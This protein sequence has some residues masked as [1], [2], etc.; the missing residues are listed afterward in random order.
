MISFDFPLAFT[1]I[2]IFLGIWIWYT[3]EK[4]GNTS[5]NIFLKKYT[6]TPKISIFLWTIR[7][8][9]VIILASIIASP[10]MII[11]T[12]KTI[13]EPKNIMIVLDIS[14]SMLAEDILPNRMEIAK[15]SLQDFL[16]SRENDRF[17]LV[18]FAG[19]AFHLVSNSSDT[20]GISGLIESISPSYIRQ[21][22]PGLS[23]TNI[24]DALLL[25]HTI[26]KSSASEKYIILITD[27]NANIGSN[28]EE[29]ATMISGEN[30]AI[31]TIGIGTKKS[32][33]LAY[34]DASGQKK[35]FYDE[36]WEK[37]VNDLD[38]EK[39]K[40]ISDIS[41]GQYFSAENISELSRAMSETDTKI[42]KKYTT[43]TTT[44]KSPLFP[45]LMIFLIILLFWEKF[46]EKKFLKKFDILA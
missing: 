21:E 8:M 31:Y 2:P 23:G 30:I 36:K 12:N 45:F 9:I 35:Y 25:G 14:R 17:S 42:G 46:L 6:K 41:G 32:E 39:L 44:Q 13:I 4:Y 26:L 19:K 1:I 43:E 33:P 11:T 28:P 15:K 18:I 16:G 24:G 3:K 10:H 40:K 38:D 7:A 34:T 37:I 22:K 29:V 27:G 20:T 5:P